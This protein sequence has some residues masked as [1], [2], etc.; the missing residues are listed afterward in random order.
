MSEIS[1]QNIFWMTYY[2]VL[3][4]AII[5]FICK[6]GLFFFRKQMKKMKK[7]KERKE[8]L[9]YVFN[10]IISLY[11]NA[12]VKKI[13]NEIFRS[14]PQHVKTFLPNTHQAYLSY[15][16]SSSRYV[17]RNDLKNLIL[18]CVSC[19][20][21]KIKKIFD[22]EKKIQNILAKVKEG[23]EK[24]KESEFLSYASLVQE[25]ELEKTRIEELGKKIISLGLLEENF[26]KEFK[27]FILLYNPEEEEKETE[28]KNPNIM[29]PEDGD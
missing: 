11:H 8:N 18:L 5:F 28:R 9:D 26:L 15:T 12:S 29:G 13:V 17:N 14:F 1:F 6:L 21:Q 3:S 2:V 10:W 25:K 27:E 20:S 16:L 7:E 22:V 4:L 19:E 24:I 23:K